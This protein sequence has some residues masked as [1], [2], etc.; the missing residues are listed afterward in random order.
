MFTGGPVGQHGINNNT[1]IYR[2]FTQKQSI[3]S[4]NSIVLDNPIVPDVPTV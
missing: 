3:V 2:I 1:L 4:S